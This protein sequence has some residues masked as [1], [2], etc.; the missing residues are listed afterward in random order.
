LI[1]LSFSAIFILMQESRKSKGD[2][3]G[4]SFGILIHPFM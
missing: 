4:K 3:S 1:V 2:N